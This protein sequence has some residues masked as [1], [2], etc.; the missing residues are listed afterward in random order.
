MLG[1][2]HHHQGKGIRAVLRIRSRDPVPF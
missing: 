2:L 1:P